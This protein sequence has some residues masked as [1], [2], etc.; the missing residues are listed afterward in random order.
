MAGSAPRVG[1]LAL[2]GAFRE[3]VALLRR[4][5]AD[6]FEV[7][8]P[9]E[10]A[11]ADALVLPGGESTTMDLLLGSSGL[12]EPL[13]ERIAG[14]TPVL[15]TCAGLILLARDLEDGVEGQRTFAA[16]DVTALR[17]GYGRQVASFEA[18]VDLAG[19]PEPMNGVFIRA[20][21]ITRVGEGVEVI[22]A[23]EGEPVAVR[24]GTITAA[25]FHPELTDDVRLHQRFLDRI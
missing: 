22:G 4:L 25:T 16:L 17:N 10:L 21:R 5:G 14:G 18:R 15:A 7:R 23:V 6:A 9:A 1:V 13:A 3:H 8:T 24:S 19:D 20:P 2:Q 11:T 12:R